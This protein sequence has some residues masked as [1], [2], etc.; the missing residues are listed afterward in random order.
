[1]NLSAPFIRRPVA[2]LLIMLGL[3]LSGLVGYVQLPISDLPNVD[4][5]TLQVNVTLPG[6]SPETM[7]AAVAT[8]LEQ[9]FS[10]IAGLSS[11]NS[12]SVQGST[13]ITLQFDLDRD[14]DAAAQD[15]QTAIAQASRQL[16]RDLPNP[17]SLRK[18]N[19][20]DQPIFY[21][22]LNSTVLPLSE[23]DRYAE[24]LIAQRL[25][26]LDG[27]A[28][29]QV[30]GAQKYAVRIQF[31]P[32]A[33]TSQGIGLDEAFEAIASGNANLPTGNLYGRRQTYVVESDG[34]LTN[35]AGYRS[36]VLTTRNGVPV[37]LGDVAEVSDSVQNDQ[38]ASWY[39]GRRS[40]V[41][42]IQ[43]QPGTNTV[44][45]VDAIRELLP[46][47]REQMP[48]AINLEVLFDRSEAVRE[49]LQDVQVTLAITIGLVVLVV[50]LFLGRLG[51]T[52]I[53]AAA[54]ILSLV[55]S[56]GVMRLLGY[57]LDN[58]S[59]MALTLSVGFVVDDAIVMLE[60]IV[61]RMELGESREQAALR[62]S[63]EIAFT[64]LSIT[65]SLV[66]VFIPVLFMGGILGRLFREFAVTL[67]IAILISGLVSLTL[68]PMLCARF[69]P[70]PSKEG[71]GGVPWFDRRFDQL[72]QFYARSLGWCLQHPRRVQAGSLGVLVLTGLLLVAVPKG[73][74]PNIDNGQLTATTQAGQGVTFEQMSRYHEKLSRILLKN[75]NVAAVNSTVGAGG[76]NASASN[77]R[78]FIR[79]KPRHERPLS[80][81][82]LVQKLRRQLN[83]LP[84]LRTFLQNPPAISLGGQQTKAQYQFTLQ[85][86]EPGPL[87]EATPKL[88]EALRKLPRLQDVNS[89]LLLNTPQLRVEVDRDLA[90]SLGVNATQVET[91][92]GNAYAQRQVSTIYAPD[93]QYA[94]IAGVQRG[95][96]ATPEALDLLSVRNREGALVPLNAIATVRPAS[97]LASINHV[98]Q[99]PA[100]TISF[101]LKPGVSLGDVTPQIEALAQRL[102]P[103]SVTTRFQGTAQVFQDSLGNLGWLLLAA[104]LVIYLVLGILYEDVLHPLTIL[105]S[106]PSAGVGAF[107]ALLLCGSELNL[108]SFVG[109]ILLIGIVKKNG[110]MM[111]DVAIALRRQ[112]IKARRAIY[113]A[114]LIRFRPI[115]MTTFAALFGSLPIALGWGAGAEARR[116]L[117]LAV[118][119]GLL[120][121][122]LLTLYIT[123]VF[124]VFA[125]GWAE[126]WGW[127]KPDQPQPPVITPE[128]VG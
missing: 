60:A 36:L 1:M 108:Y 93:N 27:V 98:G 44:A 50:F 120:L 58:L 17:P 51:T 6:A 32:Q 22:S 12:N 106:L 9:Q 28:Q 95:I 68:T 112:G 43:R 78:L 107:L 2:T 126:R 102:L 67:S 47:F 77:G 30:F 66:A 42:A 75:P 54:V 62:G 101:N 29:V 74:I 92:L 104:V 13:Q 71:H 97:T 121:S 125:E 122:Q 73:F 26:S 65:I 52:A 31:D 57:S 16:P 103:S 63:G 40:I 127:R 84:G 25:S 69:L 123:P 11:L 39:N 46:R 24:T 114:S 116:P 76:P 85:A 38:L 49:S 87:L 55:G 61:R 89:D 115:M 41:L 37:K 81:D 105:T 64:I 15:V 5:P 48:A 113:E 80:A 18:V 21:L 10:S 99:L 117:G 83:G 72:Q 14:V 35:A 34:Q 3:L 79:L 111:V 33:L 94:V 91:A 23:V 20:A 70:L 96:Q 8:P 90:S 128:R 119:G 88:E 86:L 53:P 45:I 124:Y 109:L 110:I 19:P 59:L 118:V 56:F 7:A 4:F 82:E 100:A